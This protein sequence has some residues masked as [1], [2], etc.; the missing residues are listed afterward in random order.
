[1]YLLGHSFD[2]VQLFHEDVGPCPVFFSGRVIAIQVPLPGSDVP[3]SI[4]VEQRTSKGLLV[5]EYQDLDDG[6]HF[7]WPLDLS[8]PSSVA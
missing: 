2:F 5:S 1:M 6:L 8:F 4:L 7:D 3:W